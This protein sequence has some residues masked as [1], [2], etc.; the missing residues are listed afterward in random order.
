MG[1][2]RRPFVL[3]PL[4][5]LLL[6]AAAVIGGYTLLPGVVRSQSQGWVE[7]NLPGKTLTMGDIAFDP[8]HLQLDIKDI[9]IADGKAPQ[10]PLVAIK[11]LTVDAG[12][13]SLWK[14][15]PQLDAVTIDTPVIDAILRPD[16]S[17]NL[18]EL[19]PV[20]DGEPIPEVWIGD[21]SVA[22]GV[23]GFTDAR[24]A[25]LQSQR[26]TPVT[27][28]LKDFATT[29]TAGGG[30]KFDAASDAGEKFAWAG[31]LSMAP[32]SSSGRFSIGALKL[33]TISRF[34]GDLLPV[35]MTDGAID[36]A[37]QYGFAIPAAAKGAPAPAPKFDADVTTLALRDAAIT[38]STGDRIGI[39]ALR[40]APQRSR[41][42]AMR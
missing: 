3:I 37:G 29:S 41:S 14:L 39:K 26:L 10:A 27:F 36:I 23:I 33:A 13:A 31:K 38:A 35:T 19:V 30:F 7:T 40:V 9:A 22:N 5:L 11:A 18:A 17:L 32:V 1:L 16:G 4:V 21:L 6:F 2:L 12:I 24:R 20:D 28:N 8:W 42:P 25:K 34:A 15:S